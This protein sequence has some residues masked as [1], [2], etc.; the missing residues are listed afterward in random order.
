[1]LFQQKLFAWLAFVLFSASV[2]TG[3][4]VYIISTDLE[5]GSNQFGTIDLTTGAFQRIGSDLEGST[6]LASGPTGSLLTLSFL[7][8][9]NAINATNGSSTPIGFTGLG[10]CSTPTSACP[11]NSANTI[12]GSGASIYATDLVN[13]LYRVNPSTGAATLVGP[14]G[15]PAIPFIPLS[16]NADGTFNAYDEALFIANGKLYATF[17]A[18]TVDSTTFTLRTVLIPDRL[19]QIDPTTGATAVIGPTDLNLAAAAEV[20]GIVYAFSLGASQ[21]VSLDLANGNTSFVTDLDPAAGIVTGAVATPEPYSMSL[22]GIGILAI[23]VYRTRR[24]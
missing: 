15:I 16:E 7:G 24:R 3:S 11:P 19:Y 6:G 20:N 2:C 14:T 9:L 4:S 5:T 13:R 8:G 1:M 10:D 21:I 18:F 12:G 23:A 17:D 22:A